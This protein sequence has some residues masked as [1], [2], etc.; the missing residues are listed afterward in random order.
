MKRV[1]PRLFFD[2][3]LAGSSASRRSRE[4]T[5]TR[6]RLRRIASLSAGRASV[7]VA[8]VA[9]LIFIARAV[10]GL[11]TAQRLSGDEP[12]PAPAKFVVERLRGKVVW[13]SEAMERKFDVKPVEELRR[14]AVAIE[15]DGGELHPI[16]D[17]VRGR[18]FRRDERLRDVPMELLVR[19][20]AG[21]PVVQVIGVYAI[22]KGRK[23]EIDYWCQVCA[24][25]MY[26]QKYCECCQGETELRRRPVRE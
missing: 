7:Q 6:G 24:I 13:Q 2:C 12:A 23:F 21:S 22:E 1:T 18:G 25:A 10:G 5:P 3:A 15:T 26:E 20:Y 11:P 9:I 4:S 14:A 16:F 8:L 19:R 17:D